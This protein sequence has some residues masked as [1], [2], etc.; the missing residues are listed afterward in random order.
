MDNRGFTLVELLAVVCIVALVGTIAVPNILKSLDIGKDSSDRVLY[1]NIRTAL[2]TMYEEIRYN[3]AE[4]Y[5][6]TTSSATAGSNISIAVGDSITTNVQ[7]LVG[8]GFLTGINNEDKSV[9]KNYKIVLNSEGKDIGV[10]E[11]KVTRKKDG[12]KYSYEFI[13]STTPGCPTTDDLKGE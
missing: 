4:V 13:G 10:C 7:T 3:E 12:N 1:G 2:Q 9:N 11:V 8:N 5:S 6:Y